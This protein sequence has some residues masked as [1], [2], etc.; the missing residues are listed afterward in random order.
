[1]R[2]AVVVA[3]L[4]VEWT[5][6][7]VV[8]EQEVYFTQPQPLAPLHSQLLLAREVP[9]ASPTLGAM[10]EILPS[11]IMLTLLI[12]LQS[13]AVAVG[14]RTLINCILVL[15][16]T[17]D[18][19]VAAVL[20]VLAVRELRVKEMRVETIHLVLRVAVVVEVLARQG[21]MELLL[22]VL[23]VRE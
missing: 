18:Q 15:V 20:A 6:L 16:G 13:V 4:L 14:I 23:A 19:E 5:M 9:K 3:V 8:V 21:Q 17:V 12:L 11:R 22:A 10:E 7:Q 2:V 1:L